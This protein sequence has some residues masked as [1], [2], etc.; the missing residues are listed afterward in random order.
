MDKAFRLTINAT[1]RG[2]C[3]MEFTQSCEITQ[4]EKD[5]RTAGRTHGSHP[6]PHATDTV[7]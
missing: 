7:E 5:E 2:L 4:R 1:R 3:R 6:H